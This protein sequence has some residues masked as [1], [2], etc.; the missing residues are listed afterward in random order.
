MRLIDENT[1]DWVVWLALVAFWTFGFL[2]GKNF[3]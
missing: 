2:V 3:F 1:K